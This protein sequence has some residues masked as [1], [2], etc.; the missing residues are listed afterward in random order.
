MSLVLIVDSLNSIV[1]EKL[2]RIVIIYSIHQPKYLSRIVY[3]AHIRSCQR[4]TTYTL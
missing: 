4:G 2:E 1:E 3:T